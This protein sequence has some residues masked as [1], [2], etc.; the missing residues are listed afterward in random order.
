M[1]IKSSRRDFLK[2]SLATGAMLVIGLNSDGVFAAGT[3][4]ATLN[5][6][7]KISGDGNLTVILKHIEMG[8]G[9]S[10]GL[11]TL[12]AEELDVE[13][14]KVKTEFAPADVGKY[15]NLMMGM[16]GTGGSTSIANSYLQYRK[17]GAA[18]RDVLVRA[19]ASKWGISPSEV[20]IEN[21]RLKAGNKSAHF[22]E[23]IAEAAKLTPPAEPILK[24][25]SDF[26]LIGNRKIHRK[27]HISKTNGTAIFALDVKIPGMV[28]AVILHKPQFGAK[29]KNFDASEAKSIKGFIDAKALPTNEGVAI[30]ANSTW[31]ALKA[32]DAITADWDLSAAEMRSSDQMFND[33]S[34]LLD[35]PTYAVRGDRETVRKANMEAAQKLEV[36]FRLPFLA[37]APMEPQN[38]VIEPTKTG[39]IVHDGCQMPTLVQQMVADILGLKTENVLVNT[40]YAGGSFG[41]RAN[42]TSDYVTEAAMAFSLLGGKTPVKLVWSRED[43]IHA[44]Y[45]RPL[46]VHKVSVG[47]DNQG[48]IVGWDHRIASKSIMKGTFLEAMAVQNGI[49]NSSTEGCADTGY[50]IPD[51]SVGLSDFIT[52]VTALWWRSVGHSVTGIV[53]EVT[54]DMAAKAAGEDPVDFRLKLLPGNTPAQKRMA[55]VLK[56]A[57]DKADW[58]KPLPAGWGRGIA[59]HESFGSFVAEV[60]EISTNGDDIKIERVVCVVDCGLIINPDVVTAQIESGVGYGLGAAMRNQISFTDGVIDQSNFPD[61]EPLRIADIGKIDVYQVKSDEAP[62][63]IGE[64]GVPPSGP[65][66]INAIADATGKRVTY[67]PLSENGISFV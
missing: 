64:P 30:Y 3:A 32:R 43:D 48:A 66:L 39:V 11:T 44:G 45:F 55:N 8:Q 28:Y 62:S 31:N 1:N 20:T 60:V 67:L 6:F 61:Y 26:K 37:H 34:A 59:V 38:C 17:A 54:M 40:V 2:G 24:K 42:P 27:D 49:D 36:E 21:G 53:M 15:A 16:Q 12:V 35:N 22:G 58:K 33:A 25:N 13:W 56:M 52:P 57:A 63:G 9:T 18:A 47:L 19:A 14:D 65:A 51:M 50:E 10:T 7:V 23:V 41:R 46:A 4:D 5:P 29:L